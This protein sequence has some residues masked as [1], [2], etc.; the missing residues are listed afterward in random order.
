MTNENM[1]GY[2][3]FDGRKWLASDEKTWTD[4]FYDAASFNDAE[5]AQSIGEREE[6][7]RVIYVLGC[8]PSA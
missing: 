2:Y 7:G 6:G 4:D 5:L 1:L 8:L 3:V